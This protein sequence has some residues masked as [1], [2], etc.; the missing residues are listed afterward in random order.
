[1]ELTMHPMLQKVNSFYCHN[2]KHGR[3]SE[4]YCRSCVV[5][6]AERNVHGLGG[7]KS[8]DTLKW[9]IVRRELIFDHNLCITAFSEDVQKEGT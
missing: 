9:C 1:M 8:E 4:E 3:S 7:W 2:A 5:D 6:A